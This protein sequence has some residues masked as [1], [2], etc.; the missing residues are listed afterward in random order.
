[1]INYIQTC[2]SL[3]CELFF[4][5]PCRQEN[6]TNTGE[7]TQQVLKKQPE[8]FITKYAE[9]LDVLIDMKQVQIVQVAGS[10]K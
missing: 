7:K 9:N 3:I 4:L 10:I 2:P 8:L 1:M 6:L 5:K